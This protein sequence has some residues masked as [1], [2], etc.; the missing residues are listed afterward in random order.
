MRLRGSSAGLYSI[1]S[2]FAPVMIDTRKFTICAVVF[3]A[4]ITDT[5]GRTDH[6]A[7]GKHFRFAL[8]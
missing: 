1:E 4:D 5:G 2:G 3:T 8:K 7:Q 6:E